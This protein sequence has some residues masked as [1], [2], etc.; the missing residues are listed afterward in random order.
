[1]NPQA[2]ISD[3]PW[4]WLLVFSTIALGAIVAVGPK[5]GHRQARIE[6][7]YQARE[8]LASDAAGENTGPD[9]ATSAVQADS[10]DFATSKDTLVPLWPLAIVLSAVASVA[11]AML[12][13]NL[14][15]GRRQAGE[16]GAASRSKESAPP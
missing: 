3:S 8:R 12:A 10:R 1:M 6:R 4:F 9:L 14:I 2:P 16:R 15:A 7:Q 5:Y 11:A 13:R